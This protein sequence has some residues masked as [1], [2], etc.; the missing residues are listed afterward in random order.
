MNNP[1]HEGLKNKDLKDLVKNVFEIDTFRSKMGDDADVA[2]LSFEVTNHDAANDLVNF[3]EKG[4]DF[5]L[6]AD[7]SSGEVKTNAYKVFVEIERS[8]KLSDQI[9]ELIYGIDQ[10]C[11]V[12]EWLFRYYRDFKSLP[13][14]ELGKI[15][16]NSPEAYK[17]KMDSV[18]ESDMKFFFRRSPLDYL[19][20]EEN[21]MTFKRSYNSPVR[22]E[23][24]NYGTRTD[25]L[26]QLAGTIRIDETSTSESMWLTKYFG[27]YNIT[28]YGDDFVFETDNNV[29]VLRLTK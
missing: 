3:I 16:P 15:V 24:I 10:L 25:I 13:L 2:V 6:D 21:V 12:K 7:V 11:D 29:L 1:L 19:L 23:L 18:F 20:I 17:K 26:N 14:S 4:Y 5:V 8:K 9:N 27:D 28:K 22:M